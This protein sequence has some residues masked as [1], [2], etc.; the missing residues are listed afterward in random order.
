MNKTSRGSA[1]A[2][3]SVVTALFYAGCHT[4]HPTTQ[5]TRTQAAPVARPNLAA[6]ACQ[7]RGPV[8]CATSP[9]DA[10]DPC[11]QLAGCIENLG[12]PETGK[13]VFVYR[14]EKPRRLVAPPG[15]GQLAVLRVEADQGERYA[16]TSDTDFAP[17]PHAGEAAFLLAE[18][19]G[20]W[21][22]ID[23]LLSWDWDTMGRIEDDY[24][25]T[26]L[27]ANGSSEIVIV[28]EHVSRL[29]LD[30]E[31]R[32]DGVDDVRYATCATGRYGLASGR[33]TRIAASVA[34]GQCA[35]TR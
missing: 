17:H 20:G 10:V 1:E 11:K 27:P 31:E 2:A 32:E 30:P 4:P 25:A 29:E 6:P 7:G 3:L 33:Y 9:A 12:D 23:Q 8:D 13:P 18:R 15:A 21:C 16:V 22:L 24:Q 26:A 35:T 19:D 5:P 34:D 28:S 14:C